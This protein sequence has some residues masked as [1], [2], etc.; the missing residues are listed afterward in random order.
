LKNRQEISNVRR[1]W[2]SALIMMSTDQLHAFGGNPFSDSA[3]GGLM[4]V[5]PRTSIPS[6]VRFFRE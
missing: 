1:I 5:D 6:G 4:E 2:R 3:L